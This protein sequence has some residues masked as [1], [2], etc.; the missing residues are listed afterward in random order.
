MA[1]VFILHALDRP[2]H[3]EIERPRLKCASL[4]IF[5]RVEVFQSDAPR[6]IHPRNNYI[7]HMRPAKIQ[8][9]LEIRF[10]T[11]RMA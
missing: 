2:T 9:S 1:F 5:L 4:F 6:R 3:V 8:I 7:C 11:C 10:S